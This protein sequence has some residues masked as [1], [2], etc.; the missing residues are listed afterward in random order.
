MDVLMERSLEKEREAAR[1]DIQRV[2]EEKDREIEKHKEIIS[3]TTQRFDTMMEQEGEEHD[4]EL[5]VLKANAK[6]DLEQQRAIEYMLKKEQDT[7]LR[8]LDMMEKD[9]ERVAKEK[10]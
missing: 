7:L 4:H 10:E 1:V 6:D 3:F 5:N 8:G 9:T 2:I